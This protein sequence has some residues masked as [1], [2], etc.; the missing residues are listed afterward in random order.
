MEFQLQRL[1]K[2]R[3][4]LSKSERWRKQAEILGLSREARLKLEWFVYYHD[5]AG[6]NALKTC[7][8]FGI[9]KTRFYKWLSV[10]DATN[11]KALEEA[12]RAP[13][14]RRRSVVN[15]VEEDRILALRKSN[16]EFGKMK[17]KALY[18]RMYQDSISSW[19]IQLVIEKHR[20]Q[21]R[22]S[23]RVQGFKKQAFSKRKTVELVKQQQPG[24]LMAF[25]SVVLYRNGVKRYVVTGIDTVSK[26]AWAR[27]YTNHS[28]VTTK[29]LFIRLYAITHGNIL[30]V[31]SDNGSEFEKHFQSALSSLDIPR[32]YSRLQTPKDNPVCERFNSTIKREFLR[33][34]NW[35]EDVHEFNR[36][37]SEWLLKYNCVRPHQTLNYLT[38]FEY[39]FN[40]PLVRDVVI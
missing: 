18:A 13:V 37:L 4:L 29:D 39:H 10:F 7:R 24:F 12:S 15:Q 5:R 9:S 33:M 3:P 11:L 19:K 21:R 2:H 32:H 36:R 27:M 1:Y 28:S 31:C 14:K 23:G 30:N 6:K 26:V 25:D 8:Y 16:P 20:L 34:G 17:I 22:P 38:P 35:T 40:Q